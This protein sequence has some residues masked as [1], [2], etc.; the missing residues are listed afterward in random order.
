MLSSFE[1]SSRTNAV[2]LQVYKSPHYHEYISKSQCNVEPWENEAT[3]VMPIKSLM[4]LIIDITSNSR[5][6]IR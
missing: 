4:N 6:A 3:A 1:F 5:F 2:G